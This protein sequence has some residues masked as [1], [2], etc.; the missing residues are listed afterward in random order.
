MYDSSD[1]AV[2]GRRTALSG[3]VVGPV[4]I[5]RFP[6]EVAIENGCERQRAPHASELGCVCITAL[7]ILWLLQ[8]DKNRVGGVREALTRNGSQAK[9]ACHFSGRGD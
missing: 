3:I 8:E 9:Y 1:L 4:Q 2:N 6:T 7:K 5:G